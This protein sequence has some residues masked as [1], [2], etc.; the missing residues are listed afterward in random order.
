MMLSLI[1]IADGLPPHIGHGPYRRLASFS[2][3]G[4]AR[5]AAAGTNT[6]GCPR[7]RCRSFHERDERESIEPGQQRIAEA[8]PLARNL[9]LCGFDSFQEMSNY[10]PVELRSVSVDDAETFS[11]HSTFG[12]SSGQRRTPFL[13]RFSGHGDRVTFHKGDKRKP[14]NVPSKTE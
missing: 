3:T 1:I 6:R 5:S 2:S 4:L 9:E 11:A 8:L 13:A 10:V 7:S 14:Q 12:D